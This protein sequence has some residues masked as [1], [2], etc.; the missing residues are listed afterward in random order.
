MEALLGNVPV[1]VSQVVRVL[2]WI[3]VAGLVA[4]SL[5][6]VRRAGQSTSPDIPIPIPT[7]SRVAG[8]S[9]LAVPAVALVLGTVW[10][11]RHYELL[12]PLGRSD[13]A[14]D[15]T[16]AR[17]DGKPGNVKLADLRGRGGV[18][19]FL[20]HLVSAVPGHAADAA[21][22]STENGSRAAPSSSASTRTGR[23]ISRDELRAF[24]ARRPFSRTR[25]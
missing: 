18:A 14:P 17:V 2:A 8:L 13:K 20:G 4:L 12:R 7:R 21:R 1:A 11:A 10:S 22:A 16:L 6:L 23:M 24:L 3:W 25:W 19:R 15:F 5:L 9:V